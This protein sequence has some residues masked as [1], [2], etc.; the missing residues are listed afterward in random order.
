MSARDQLKQEMAS[1]PE[2]VIE[3]LLI[4][5]HSLPAPQTPSPLNG[6]HFASYWSRWYGALGDEPWDEPAE[7]PFEKREAW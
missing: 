2:S 1:L 7:L 5:L 6:D 3:R 4:Y